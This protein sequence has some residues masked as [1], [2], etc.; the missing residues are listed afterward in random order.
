[1]PLPPFN[2]IF[3]FRHSIASTY[4]FMKR[5]PKTTSTASLF[6]AMNGTRYVMFPNR[7]RNT[8]SPSRREDLPFASPSVESTVSFVSHVFHPSVSESGLKMFIPEPVSNTVLYGSILRP[9]SPIGH[10]IT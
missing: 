1:M 9:S 3:W 8:I 2:R 4:R 7:V 5:V 10:E 6:A